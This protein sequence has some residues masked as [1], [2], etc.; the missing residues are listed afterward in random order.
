MP[1]FPFFLVCFLFFLVSEASTTKP[2]KKEKKDNSSTIV[3]EL[4]KSWYQSYWVEQSPELSTTHPISGGLHHDRS[5]VNESNEDSA[6]SAIC[7]SGVVLVGQT[8]IFLRIWLRCW[9]LLTRC[10]GCNAQFLSFAVT[11]RGK[12]CSKGVF[13]PFSYFDYNCTV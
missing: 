9:L 12:D 13:T 3:I 11:V 1:F 2:K 10:V 7:W 8:Q 4:P 5:I 6:Y